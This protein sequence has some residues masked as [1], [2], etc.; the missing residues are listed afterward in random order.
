M[1]IT[2]I[3]AFVAA[4]T[5]TAVLGAGTVP[6]ASRADLEAS[7]RRRPEQEEAQGDHATTAART[8]AMPDPC[9]ALDPR[10]GQATGPDHDR[11]Q[12]GDPIGPVQ[13][14]CAVGRARPIDDSSDIVVSVVALPAGRGSREGE[15]GRRRQGLW[16][17]GQRSRRLRNRQV[18][19]PGRRRG[20]RTGGQV[21]A[22]G[23]LRQLVHRHCDGTRPPG[24]GGSGRQDRRREDV[25]AHHGRRRHARPVAA[26]YTVALRLDDAGAEPALIAAATGIELE[27]VSG[28][29]AVAHTKLQ[30]LTARG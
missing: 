8:G 24:R 12:A 3:R 21:P 30:E 11:G 18:R 27:S 26:L 25:D 10:R 29:L 20:R 17:A 28:F 22:H 19:D 2:A 9:R 16:E 23:R 14:A 6:S 7:P 13:Q 4:T 1:R 5:V 15:L